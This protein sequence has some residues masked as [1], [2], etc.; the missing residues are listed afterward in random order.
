VD[1]FFKQWTLYLAV[2][3]EAGAG[4]IIGL[5]AIEAA[6]RALILFFRRTGD[7]EEI[8]LKL[9]RW[10]ALAGAGAGVRACRRCAPHRG[11]PDVG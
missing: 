4:L 10:L 5:A 6:V 11:G 7:A 3:V 9:G 8:R 1:E 2:G